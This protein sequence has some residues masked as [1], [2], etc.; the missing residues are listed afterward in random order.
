MKL[1]Q[2][3]QG[4]TPEVAERIRLMLINCLGVDP[5]YVVVQRHAQLT[6][7]WRVVYAPTKKAVLAHALIAAYRQGRHDIQCHDSEPMQ[8]QP[9]TIRYR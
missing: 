2:V 8:F 7:D 5:A 9:S 4:E 1:E 3:T 6:S